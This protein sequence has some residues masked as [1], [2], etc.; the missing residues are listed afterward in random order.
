M[1]SS[2]T[3]VDA[4]RH[5]SRRLYFLL[6][7]LGTGAAVRLYFAWLTFLN[8]DEALHYFVARQPSFA[9]AYK[10]SLTMAHP[11][12]M[13]ILLH[14]WSAL[15]ASEFFLRVP[16]VVA[17]LLFA[18]VMFLWIRHI[19]S[20][21]AG[22]FA[23]ALCLFLPCVI[24]L[25]AEIRQYSVLLL[26]CAACLYAL[27]LGLESNSITWLAASF[28]ALYLALL[29]HY[30]ALIFAAAVG[31]Y[32]LLLLARAGVPAR[33][34]AAWASGQLLALGICGFLFKSQ[35]APLRHSGVP[36]EIAGTWLRSS[37]FQPGHDHVF[38]FIAGKTV[39]LFRYFFSHGTIGILGLVL[40]LY[41]VWVLWRRGGSN[42]ARAFLL[43]FPFVIMLAAALLGIY[44][45]GGTRHDVLLVIFAIA[46]IAIGLDGL[47]LQA[48]RIRSSAAKC[49]VLALG[50]LICNFFP[51]PTG[52]TIRPQNQSRRLMSEAVQ[53]VRSRPSNEALLTDYQSGLVLS[54]YLCGR[55]TVLPFGENSDRLLRWPCGEHSVLTSLRS[56]QGLNPPDLLRTI[57][58]SRTA[59]SNERS[60][61]LFQS[62]WIEDQKQEWITAFQNAGCADQ[63]NFGANIR[64]C[65]ISKSSGQH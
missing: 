4:S 48:F 49:M 44:P 21:A 7:M 15:G 58:Q 43:I 18:W 27:E 10:A 1:A 16:F 29:T 63:H 42:R 20:Q 41:G 45:Y 26:F 65:Q 55:Q 59:L 56:Q 36:S 32:G 30:S 24:S 17:G 39:R 64:L 22:A 19:A 46:G 62:G 2:E 14:A 11:P 33:T 9:A 35:I 12:L 31:V 6:L 53:F 57:G 5:A 25:S 28:A 13:I 40:F 37:I 52:P 8:P 60:L 3:L 23:L 50:L 51:S 47:D 61:W 54:F 38:A 34:R